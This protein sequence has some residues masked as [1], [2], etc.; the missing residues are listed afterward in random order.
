MKIF[1]TGAT[2]FLGRHLLPALLAEGH[3][4]VAL[5][6][7]Q[8]RLD[9]FS[10]LDRKI[11][12][13]SVED[14]FK[15][16][17]DSNPGIDVVVHTA[18]IYGRHHEDCAEMLAV[19]T[20]MPLSLVEA[21]IKSGVGFFINTDSALPRD[22][23]PYSISKAQFTDWGRWFGENGK[24]YFADVKLEHM[25]GPGDDESKFTSFVI[26]ACREN[27]ESL[28]LTLGESKRDFIYIDDVVSAYLCL[29]QSKRDD[30]PGYEEFPLGSG[31]AGSTRSFVELVHKLSGSCTRLEFGA[32]PY[33]TNEVMLSVADTSKLNSLGWKCET[34]LEI[35]IRK[36][37]GELQ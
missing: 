30:P 23:T 34:S 17:F 5:R 15:A 25:F 37:L 24:I 14:G 3:E 12:W 27:R 8:S 36:V 26:N 1:L 4:I 13:V 10:G 33:R 11:N 28:P 29:L 22:M 31:F 20:E 21:A 35:G 6:R 2:G 32:V 19:N 9:K 18:A 7:A 16:A